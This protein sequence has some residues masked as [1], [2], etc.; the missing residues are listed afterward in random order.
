[1]RHGANQGCIIANS[2]IAIDVGGAGEVVLRDVFVAL[3][4]RVERVGAKHDAH[5]ANVVKM[6][7]VAPAR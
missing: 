6:N 5:G 2:D 3:V 7:E 4:S 1:V